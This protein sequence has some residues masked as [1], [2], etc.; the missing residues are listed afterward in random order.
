M[1]TR[2]SVRVAESA[3]PGWKTDRGRVFA[4]N[5]VPDEVLRRNQQGNAPP[6]E[7]WRY[8]KNKGRYYIFADRTGFG[9]MNLI[10]TNDLQE[11]GIPNWQKILGLDAVQDIG[12]FLGFD[13]I[14]IDPGAA[15]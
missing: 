7:V 4:R 14:K 13:L 12:R 9:A 15:F 5:G 6:Y 10:N 8:S 2:T 11:N 1:P 3:S